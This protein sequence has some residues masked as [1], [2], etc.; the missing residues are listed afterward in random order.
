MKVWIL[1]NAYIPEK[2][3]LVSYAKNIAKAILDTEDEVEIITSNLKKKELLPVEIIDGVKVSRIDYSGIPKLLKIFSPIIYYKRNKKFLKKIKFGK[4]DIVIS[5]FYSFAA[6]IESLNKEVK[7]IFITPLVAAKLQKIEAKKVKNIFKKIYSYLVIPQINILDRMAIRKSTII[8]VLSKSKKEEVEKEYHIE[9]KKVD[10]FYPGIDE[11][12]FNLVSKEEKIQLRKKLGFK[13]QEKIL[14]CVARLEAE[15]N[16]EIVIDCMENLKEQNYSLYFV[17]DG[18]NRQLLQQKIEERNLQNQVK[19]LG[20]K[21]NVEDY[22]KA[23]DVFI[24][25][26]KYEGFG[27]VYLEALACGLP[28]IA[29]K[30]NPPETIT[31][32]SEIITSDK[33]GK[34]VAYNNKVEILEAI[35]F[36]M[37]TSE[38]YSN[39]RNQYV[40]QKFNWKNHYLQIKGVLN[41]G[42]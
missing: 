36:C 1:T 2:G 15:K 11:R 35:Q 5:R 12:R 39:D 10:V 34:V 9:S 8:G 14:L 32:S 17:G 3:G 30:S 29:A 18:D 24:L 38:K 37:N 26:S 31:A 28:C 20:E 21:T 42:K 40:T 22:Y 23:S 27:H 33:L 25:P 4:D 16:Q 6:A 7:H 19:L 13:E 41:S